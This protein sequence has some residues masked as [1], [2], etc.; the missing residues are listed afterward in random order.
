MESISR[1][2]LTGG[3]LA[4]AA[5]PAS[6]VTVQAKGLKHRG[7]VHHLDLLAKYV[8]AGTVPRESVDLRSCGLRSRG[9]H[10]GGSSGSEE[11]NQSESA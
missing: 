7:Q 3:F 8:G 10:P 2:E 6:A 1:L 9:C 11:G 5:M 4:G